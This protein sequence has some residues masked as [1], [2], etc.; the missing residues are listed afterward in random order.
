VWFSSQPQEFPAELEKLLPAEPLAAKALKSA[1]TAINFYQALQ[2][3]DGHWPGDYG[4]ECS[5]LIWIHTDL[6]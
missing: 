3:D 5:I 2:A 6:G 1:F 4:G